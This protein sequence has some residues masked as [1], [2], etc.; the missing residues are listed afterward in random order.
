MS[1]NKRV[2]YELWSA[3]MAFLLW[4]GWAFYVNEGAGFAVGL[5]SGVVQGAASFVITLLMVR[6]VTYLYG[7]LTGRLLRLALPATITVATTGAMLVVIHRM[8]GTPHIIATIGPAL[9]VGLA[10]CAYTT[11]KLARKA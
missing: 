3:L 5:A 11:Y 9:M 1:M 8:V 2:S 6:S 7:H 4:G 10:F